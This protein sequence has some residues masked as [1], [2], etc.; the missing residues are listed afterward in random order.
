MR[1]IFPLTLAACVTAAAWGQ[2]SVSK[3][4]VRDL[5]AKLHSLNDQ[6]RLQAFEALRSDPGN[7]KNPE[8]RAELINLLD[9]E[10]RYLDS[11]LEEAQTKGYPDEGD[12]E[13]FAETY[14]DLL[15]TVDSFADWNDPRVACFLA[16]AAYNDGS[17]FAEKVARHWRT[18]IPCLLKASQSQISMSRA[19]TIPVLAEALAR[20]KESIDPAVARTARD[21]ILRALQDP[22]EAV[23][24]FTVVALGTYGDEGMI[25]ALKMVASNDPSPEVEGHSIRKS[26]AEAILQIQKRAGQQ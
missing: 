23:R 1:I 8:V 18:T 25:P 3:P 4:S 13:G 6:E 16:D 2:Q 26:A 9:R 19:T 5:L 20:A 22:D 21:I 24:S 15:E 11:Q 12:N 17:A 14:S 10:N 7:L